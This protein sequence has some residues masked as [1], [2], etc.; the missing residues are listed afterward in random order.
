[1]FFSYLIDEILILGCCVEIVNFG[2]GEY[3]FF[4]F[5]SNSVAKD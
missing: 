5:I 4:Y 1:M 3:T 2:T